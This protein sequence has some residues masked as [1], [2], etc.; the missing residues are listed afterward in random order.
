M[1]HVTF[2]VQNL[3]VI[4]VLIFRWKDGKWY[5]HAY[6]NPYDTSVRR[7]QSLIENRYAGV[8]TDQQMLVLNYQFDDIP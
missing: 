8:A 6:C 1:R 7:L 4:F 5:R 3:R 2:Y